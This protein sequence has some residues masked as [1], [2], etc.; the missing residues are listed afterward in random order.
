MADSARV[1]F[2]HGQDTELGSSCPVQKAELLIGQRNYYCPRLRSSFDK[3]DPLFA[4]NATSSTQTTMTHFRAEENESKLEALIRSSHLRTRMP[5][6]PAPSPFQQTKTTALSQ[7][8]HTGSR[9]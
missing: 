2:C 3:R 4:A 8:S 7:Y 9:D 6:A 1:K 5:K